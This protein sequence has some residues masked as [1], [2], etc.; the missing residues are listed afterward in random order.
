MPQLNDGVLHR[1]GK[2]VGDIRKMWTSSYRAAGIPPRTKIR[3]GKKIARPGARAVATLCQ[4]CVRSQLD[5][6]C[7]RSR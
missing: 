2:K 7:E 4:G 5:L 6:A 3:K 1:K